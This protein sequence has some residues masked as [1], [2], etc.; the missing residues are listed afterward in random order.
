[1]PHSPCAA[2]NPDLRPFGLRT[3]PSAQ[4]PLNRTSITMLGQRE[5]ERNAVATLHTGLRCTNRKGRDT[6]VDRCGGE[7]VPENRNDAQPQ[8]LIL[9]GTV[10]THRR[11]R[12]SYSQP[13]L[14]CRSS[15]GPTSVSGRPRLA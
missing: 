7:T 5:K 10:H 12:H 14:E 3:L 1:M 13:R 8:C 6:K 2:P 4:H 9:R 15:S 11:P